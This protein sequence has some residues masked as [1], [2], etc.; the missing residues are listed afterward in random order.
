MHM[1]RI[2]RRPATQTQYSRAASAH[3]DKEKSRPT[4][5]RKDEVNLFYTASEGIPVG[6]GTTL[7]ILSCYLRIPKLRT[8]FRFR[9]IS[10]DCCP[11]SAPPVGEWMKF[12][13]VNP[14]ARRPFRRRNLSTPGARAGFAASAGLMRSNRL[15]TGLRRPR[16]MFKTVAFR[17]PRINQYFS[18]VPPTT[19]SFACRYPHH[20]RGA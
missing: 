19:P 10:R 2:Q 12:A 8:A 14:R 16:D 13:R 18:R 3:Q 5:D 1:N 17:P 6:I 11:N 7:G 20:F 9:Q 15:Q 4:E